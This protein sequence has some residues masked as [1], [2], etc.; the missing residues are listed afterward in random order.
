MLQLFSTPQNWA[1]LWIEEAVY[2]RIFKSSI[3]G[4]P[5]R[6]FYTG[7]PATPSTGFPADMGF[8]FH[9]PAPGV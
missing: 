4:D 7:C 5:W 1:V 3:K 2:I 8:N 9:P 6:Q